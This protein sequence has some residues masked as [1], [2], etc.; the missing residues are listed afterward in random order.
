MEIPKESIVLVLFHTYVLFHL[1]LVLGR[2]HPSWA[3]TGE[4]LQRH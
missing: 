2:S 1:P 4:N 3:D